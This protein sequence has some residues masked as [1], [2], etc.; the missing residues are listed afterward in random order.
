MSSSFS[1]HCYRVCHE[2][3]DPLASGCSI[4][5]DRRTDRQSVGISEEIDGRG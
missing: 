2:G 1:F 5:S 3:S 4:D